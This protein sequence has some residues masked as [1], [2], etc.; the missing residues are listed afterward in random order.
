MLK[1]LIATP[2]FA[3]AVYLIASVFIVPHPGAQDGFRGNVGRDAVAGPSVEPHSQP[4]PRFN[5]WGSEPGR[6][7]DSEVMTCRK[8]RCPSRSVARSVAKVYVGVVITDAVKIL[9]SYQHREDT[10]VVINP[11]R[12][13]V[14]LDN[15]SWRGA[16]ITVERIKRVVKGPMKEKLQAW[17]ASPASQF[18]VMHIAGSWFS[19]SGG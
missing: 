7:I 1:R 9:A 8:A 18:Y 16:I 4:V 14:I 5:F 12:A 15:Q 19:G 17:L 2:F 3:L 11:R 10:L 6:T 13:A